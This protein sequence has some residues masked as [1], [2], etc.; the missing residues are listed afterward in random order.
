MKRDKRKLRKRKAEHAQARYHSAK[1]LAQR[2][3]TWPIQRCL[4]S[5]SWEDPTALTQIIILRGRPDMDTCAM[6]VFLVD[7]CCLGIKKG[8]IHTASQT[9]YLNV[10]ADIETRDPL[11]DCRPELAAKMLQEAKAYAAKLGFSPEADAVKALP[12]FDDVNPDE[13]TLTIPLGRNGKPFYVAGPRD[14]PQ[15]VIAQLTHA[16]GPGGF[17]YV[18]PVPGDGEPL[19]E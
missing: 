14:N 9:Q 13:C 5:R 15:K 19:S 3:S 18:V 1:H 11:M 8:F 12:I 17:D 7:Q 2:A 10:R 4:I 16:V 6:A